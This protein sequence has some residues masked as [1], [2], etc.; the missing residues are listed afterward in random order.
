MAKGSGGGGKPGRSGGGSQPGSYYEFRDKVFADK[1]VQSAMKTL[2][3][4]VASGKLSRTDALSAWKNMS[5]QA[6]EMETQGKRGW[7]QMQARA[8]A[9]NKA[10]GF[11]R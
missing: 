4:N 2:K 3:S 6:S 7:M 1:Q 9:V 8:D 10:L 5:R 11:I